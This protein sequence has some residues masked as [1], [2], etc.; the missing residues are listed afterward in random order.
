MHRKRHQRDLKGTAAVIKAVAAVI[1]AV[2]YLIAIL[3]LY[4]L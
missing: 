3:A 1:R 4:Y 2:A